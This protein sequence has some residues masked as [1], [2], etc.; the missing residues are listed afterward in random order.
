[1]ARQLGQ[2]WNAYWLLRFPYECPMTLIAL[3][4]VAEYIRLMKETTYSDVS[5]TSPSVRFGRWA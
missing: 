5:R 4:P 2:K 3:L 1:L